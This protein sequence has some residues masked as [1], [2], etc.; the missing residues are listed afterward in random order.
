MNGGA[1]DVARFVQVIILI[2]Q[3]WKSRFLFVMFTAG[4]LYSCDS[5]ILSIPNCIYA[6][7]HFADLSVVLSC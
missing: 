4:A 1:C 7:F 6:I 5:V 3:V 2:S